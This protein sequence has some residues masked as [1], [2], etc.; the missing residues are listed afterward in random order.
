MVAMYF[1]QTL[2][3]FW[4]FKNGF[5]FSDLIIY[6]LIIYIVALIYIFSFSNFKLNLKKSIFI[7]PF[8]IT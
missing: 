7:N 1:A 3:T 4:L 8:P 6:Y 5:G 2:L